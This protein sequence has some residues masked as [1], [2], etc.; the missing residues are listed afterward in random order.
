LLR[1]DQGVSARLAH[2]V[3]PVPR[4]L[5]YTIAVALKTEFFPQIRN[6][7][8]KYATLDARHGTQIIRVI[9]NEKSETML[10]LEEN[11]PSGEALSK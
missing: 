9:F 1:R 4:A 7:L 6:W 11:H 2:K 8:A 5:K 3:Q 10:K